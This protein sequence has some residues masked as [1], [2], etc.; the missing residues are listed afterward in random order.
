[1]VVNDFVA[2]TELG[3]VVYAGH[4]EYNSRSLLQLIHLGPADHKLMPYIKA[5]RQAYACIAPRPV[6]HLNQPGLE[7][8]VA[9]S[10]N[11]APCLIYRCMG[12][13]PGVQ[14]IVIARAAVGI[15]PTC[16]CNFFCEDRVDNP[17]VYTHDPC[18]IPHACYHTPL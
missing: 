8:Q 2:Q 12:I 1:M 9:V 10:C 7:R 16:S 11:N 14:A 18:L 17:Y 5:I 3:A 4:C 13:N 6:I 15:G